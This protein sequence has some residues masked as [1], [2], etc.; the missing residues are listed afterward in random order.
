[1]ECMEVAFI[2]TLINTT[3]TMSVFPM[4]VRQSQI[5]ESKTTFSKL[6]KTLN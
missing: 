3:A 6:A 4:R 5:D 1:M 2:Q